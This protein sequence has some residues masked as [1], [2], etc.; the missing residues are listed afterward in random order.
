MPLV[1]AGRPAG[2]KRRA[3]H[4]PH[5]ARPA[6]QPGGAAGMS[7]AIRLAVALLLA[8]FLAAP[9]VFAPLLRPL[10]GNNAPPVYRQGNLAL[11]TL[12]HLGL[13]LAAT[14]AASLVAVA[15]AIFVTRPAGA[16]FLPLSRAIANLGQTF[17]PVAV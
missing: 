1:R 8:A 2:G 3:P 5:H 12:S 4:R 9:D 7:W 14:L 15:A 10:A 13:T 16:E 11:I 17:P 6:E